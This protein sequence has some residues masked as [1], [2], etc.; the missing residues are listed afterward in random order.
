MRNLKP[1]VYFAAQFILCA[2]IAQNTVLYVDDSAS[3]GGNGSSWDTAFSSLQSALEA[4]SAADGAEIRVAQGVYRP[5]LGADMQAGGDARLASFKLLDNTTMLGGFFGLGSLDPIQGEPDDRDPARFKSILSGDLA[6]ND[7]DTDPPAFDDNAYHVIESWNNNETS[8]VDGFVIRDGYANRPF[9]QGWWPE[10]RDD[11]GAGAVLVSSDAV[12]RNCVFTDNHA[13]ANAWVWVALSGPFVGVEAGAGAMLI[14]GG[15]PTIEDCVFE[16]NSAS[17]LGGAVGLYASP[18]RFTRCRFIGNRIGREGFPDINFG[19]AIADASADFL[20]PERAR[21]ESCVFMANTAAG[22]GGGGA[23]FTIFSDT[24]YANSVFL[25]NHADDTA[26][27]IMCDNVANVAFHNCA[28]V[29]NTSTDTAAGV[30]EFSE[31]ADTYTFANCIVWGNRTSVP[32]ARNPNMVSESGNFA[33]YDTIVEDAFS[34]P[35]FAFDVSRLFDVDPRF[36]DP[37]GP[38]GLLYSGDENLRPAPDSPAIDNGASFRVPTWLVTDLD[39]KARFIDVPT[40]PNTGVGPEPVVDIGPYEAGPGCTPADLALP[41]GVLDF[42]D[43]VAFLTAFA[44]MEPGADLAPPLGVF[45]FSDV[46]AFLSAFAAGC[47]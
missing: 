40:A 12:F 32:V 17:R 27:G 11:S 25:A 35:I 1:C 37:V 6:G 18:A 42:S 23:V 26:G 41:F 31:I 36:T 8:I 3:P 2:A 7:D 34:R 44:A 14:S 29:G 19:G 39:T 10:R 46:V 15:A 4:A 28:I 21:V 9:E 30:Y 45:D 24:I 5:G 47:P 38:D 22:F 16:S 13:E 33:L 43:V 20:T